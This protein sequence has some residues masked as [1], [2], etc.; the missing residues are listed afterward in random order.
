MACHMQQLDMLSDLQ[1]LSLNEVFNLG[2]DSSS[3]LTGRLLLTGLR[4]RSWDSDAFASQFLLRGLGCF[5]FAV[6]VSGTRMLLLRSSPLQRTEVLHCRPCL[7]K[8]ED[9]FRANRWNLA[10]FKAYTPFR[11][12]GLEF[13]AGWPGICMFILTRLHVLSLGP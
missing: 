9:S 5:C 6:P 12:V 10:G 3:L 8:I 1:Q 13:E 2:L 11:A 4:S 7:E